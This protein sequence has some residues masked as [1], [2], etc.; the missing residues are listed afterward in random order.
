MNSSYYLPLIVGGQ[1]IDLSHLEP[2]KLQVVSTHA[3]TTLRVHV[4]FTSHCFSEKLDS[5]LLAQGDPIIDRN[6]RHPRM[7]CPTRYRLSHK[8]PGFLQ[9]LPGRSVSLTSA[10]R[11]WVY[12][13]T[14]EDPA[15]PYHVFFELGR[16]PIEQRTW[17]DLNLVVESAYPE[18][19]APPGVRGRPKPFALVCGEVY[20]GNRAKPKAKPKRR[21]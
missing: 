5:T 12:T 10:Q 17:Q 7:F 19:K 18:T 14:I 15:G 1:S 3:K 9:E 6:T 20:T 4:T 13:V 16:A 2:F 21:R 8:L 11:N